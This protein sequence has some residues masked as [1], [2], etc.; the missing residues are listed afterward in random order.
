MAPPDT[1]GLQVHASMRMRLAHFLEQLVS[2]QIGQPESL[3]SAVS[4]LRKIA[5]GSTHSSV[6]GV[7]I[8]VSHQDLGKSLV[9][10]DPLSC[11][12][13]RHVDEG[14]DVQLV[15]VW[16]KEACQFVAQ[17]TLL[18]LK[19]CGGVI[20]HQSYDPFRRTL[21]AEPLRT[22]ERVKPSVGDGI[23]IADVVKPS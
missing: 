11:G 13:G 4:R 1:D 15:L 18:R 19:L 23:C 21:L 12:T 10:G 22:V 7:L 5:A 8:G 20:R 16:S 2:P 14:E 9:D 6:H 3:G 17:A